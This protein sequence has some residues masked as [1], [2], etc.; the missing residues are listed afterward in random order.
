MLP[1][2]IVATFGMIA[3]FFYLIFIP[4]L[5]TVFREDM[6]YYINKLMENYGDEDVQIDDSLLT[7]VLTTLWIISA[8][9]AGVD[10]VILFE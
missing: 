6:I 1:G 4:L 9:S 10:D 3:L 5:G 7:A 2:L 8:I